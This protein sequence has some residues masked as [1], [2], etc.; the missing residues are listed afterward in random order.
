[1]VEV[2]ND[3][4]KFYIEDGILFSEYKRMVSVNIEYSKEVIKLRNQISNN[5]NQYWCYDI[6]NL[7]SMDLES[8]NYADK[9]GQ[10]N[11]FACAVIVNSLLTQF[12]FNVF[13]KMKK[14]NIPF[15]SFS[16]KED[17]VAWLN[18]LKIKNESN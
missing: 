11:L 2:E 6:R 13:L 9:Y 14:P 18:E 17:A 10:D 16:T 3:F 7:K 12:I 5:V 1:M 8:R 15:K 4:I